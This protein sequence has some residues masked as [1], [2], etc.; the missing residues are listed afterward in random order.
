MTCIC[1]IFSGNCEWGSW[2]EWGAC[3]SSCQRKRNRSKVTPE[4]FGGTC[5]GQACEDERCDCHVS[6]WSPW[7]AC[8][9]TCD[10]GI[11]SRVRHVLIPVAPCG[12]SCPKK[13]VDYREC[14]MG[15]CDSSTVTQVY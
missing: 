7:G 8:S 2:S 10:D 3:S 1:C 5:R 4:L 14:N 6:N 9:V 13:L 15:S 11:Q 12:K